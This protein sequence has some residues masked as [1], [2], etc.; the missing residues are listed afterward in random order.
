M[1][2]AA[3]GLGITWR[4]RSSGPRVHVEVRALGAVRV[5]QSTTAIM[6]P[7]REG[8]AAWSNSGFINSMEFK[9]G[10]RAVACRVSSPSES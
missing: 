5:V 1:W 6:W 8:R 4:R 7:L 2:G 3:G 10:G 9:V